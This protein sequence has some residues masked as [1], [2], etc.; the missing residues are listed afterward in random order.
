MVQRRSEIDPRNLLLRGLPTYVAIPIY[1]LLRACTQNVIQQ[2]QA[3][4]SRTRGDAEMET[5]A[6]ELA[7]DAQVFLQCPNVPLKWPCWIPLPCVLLMRS[8]NRT[9]TYAHQDSSHTSL[10]QPF[11]FTNCDQFQVIIYFVSPCPH[12]KN[13]SLPFTP[14]VGRT[15]CRKQY[16]CIITMGNTF[17]PDACSPGG[18]TVTSP[19][20]NRSCLITRSRVCAFVSIPSIAPSASGVGNPAG[21]FAARVGGGRQ[22]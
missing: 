12:G 21:V 10:T 8:R 9:E 11:K 20:W 14:K 17:S 19:F 18:S 6:F 4:M 7:V 3:R 5:E 13:D 2:T 16:F 22:S 15:K 1:C